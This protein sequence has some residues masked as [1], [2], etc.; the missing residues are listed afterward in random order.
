MTI[1]GLAGLLSL[2][3]GATWLAAA[4]LGVESAGWNELRWGGLAAVLVAFV[5]WGLNLL[6]GS[7]RWLDVVVGA[8]F[9]LLAWALYALL[10]DVVGAAR[11]LHGVL[12]AGF[13]LV[14]ILS[15]R[16][17]RSERSGEPDAPRPTSH[18]A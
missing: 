8:A 14:G 1:R 10:D 11:P 6:T 18:R 2:L 7:A 3:G 5:C 17:G 4:A 13:V 9:P 15:L 16:G 12:G